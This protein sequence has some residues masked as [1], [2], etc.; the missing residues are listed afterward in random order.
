[1]RLNVTSL[2][3][4]GA[5]L[6]PEVQTSIRSALSAQDKMNQDIAQL[7]TNVSAWNWQTPQFANGWK[8]FSTTLIARF[9]QL[10]CGLVVLSGAIISGTIGGTAFTLPEAMRPSQDCNFA[11]DSNDAFGKLVV[12]ASGSVIPTVGSNAFFSLDGATFLPA[13]G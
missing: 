6:P 12:Q 2:Q 7:F 9:T 10:S 11:V 8:N 1:V 4:L 3:Q 13:G 5:G